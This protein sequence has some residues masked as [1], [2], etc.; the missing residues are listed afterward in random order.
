MDEE[1]TNST[2][3]EEEKDY[4]ELG[5]ENIA[6]QIASVKGCRWEANWKRNPGH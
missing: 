3:L 1:I 5:N 4:V 6:A 2:S